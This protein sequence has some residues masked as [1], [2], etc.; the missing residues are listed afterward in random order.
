MKNIILLLFFIYPSLCLYAVNKND[1]LLKVLDK[2]IAERTQWTQKKEQTIRQLKNKKSKIKDPNE[3]YTINIEIIQQYQSFICD[4]AELYIR[5]NLNIAERLGNEEHI[6]ESKLQLSFIHSLSGLFIPAAEILG[7][8]KYKELPDHCKVGYCWNYIRYYEN[9]IKYT[10]DTTFSQSY[11]VAK[12]AVRDT[13]MSLL[14]HESDEYLKEKAFKLQDAGQ[15][16]EAADILIPIY[17]KQTPETHEYAMAAMSLAKIYNLAGDMEQEKYYLIRAAITDVQLAVK[18]NESLLSLAIKLYEDGDI[19]RAYNYIKVALDDAIFY[20]ARFRNAVIARVQPIIES[21][22]IYKIEQQQRNL[23]LYAILTSL[24]IIALAIILYFYYRQIRIVS[25]AKRN[26]RKMN[27]KLIALN[28]K[29]D[30]SNLIKEKYIGY[31]M[32]QCAVYINKLDEYRKHVNRKIKTGQIDDLYKSSSR[33]LEKEVE[34]L[35]ANFDHAFL[36]LYPDFVEEFNSLLKPEEQYKPE[37]NQLNTE[38]RIFAL[39]RLGITDVSQIAIFLRYSMQTI[40]NYKSKVKGKSL[41]GSDLFEEEVK[42][43]GS[44][45]LKNDSD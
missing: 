36:K 6:Q 11:I 25:K 7:S 15:Y 45:Y 40:Y 24:F 4:S 38:L 27:D 8:I 16:K 18:E 26:L 2:T 1:S 21:T 20:N 5:E 19:N 3:L 33:A 39:I 31:F 14:Y 44:F 42:K 13:L 23:R 41:T 28:R 32:N 17:Q 22:Y 37:N 43:I 10:D 34:E 35:Y 9:L 12:E 29:L 30:E